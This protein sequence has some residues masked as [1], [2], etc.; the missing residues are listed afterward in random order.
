MEPGAGVSRMI[1][2]TP[3]LNLSISPFKRFF[4][5]KDTYHPPGRLGSNLC[6]A[7][8]RIAGLLV[9]AMGMTFAFLKI[10]RVTES[11]ENYGE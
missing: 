5:R 7:D 2:S 3:G 4:L 9:P 8:S 6:D 1:L 10:R 11:T